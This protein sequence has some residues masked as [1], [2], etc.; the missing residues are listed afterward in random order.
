MFHL[1][2]ISD[3]VVFCVHSFW[4]PFF[5]IFPDPSRKKRRKKRKGRRNEKSAWQARYKR[6]DGPLVRPN[7]VDLRRKKKP[8]GR[9]SVM[10]N[11]RTHLWRFGFLLGSWKRRWF[12]KTCYV[13]HDVFT[14]NQKWDGKKLTKRT[15]KH[16]TV[17]KIT[18]VDRNHHK[19]PCL[20]NRSVTCCFSTSERFDFISCI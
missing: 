1:N 10:K 14:V 11:G 6:H 12:D 17:Y 20:M 2:F 18:C 15:R 8:N 9:E 7:H 4:R 19:S 13:I 16:Y 3:F 5:C